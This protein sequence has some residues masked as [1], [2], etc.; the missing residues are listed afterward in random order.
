ME[1]ITQNKVT[2]NDTIVSMLHNINMDKLD[3]FYKAASD[4]TKTL[5][6][7]NNFHNRIERLIAEKPLKFV[8]LNSL[9]NDLKKLI[10]IS[11]NTEENVFLNDLTKELIDELVIEWRNSETFKFHNLGI[12]NK[13]LFHGITGNGK[14]TIARHIAKI[15]NLPFVEINADVMID[16]KL[17]NTQYNI[18]QVLNGIKEP[19]VLFWD[20]IDS[21]GRKRGMVDGSSAGMENERM[22]NSILVNIEKLN[23][24]VIFIGATNRK[25]VLD[26][27]FI[28]RF[29]VVF[30]LTAPSLSEKDL[31]AKQMMDYYK[32]P[33]T[34]MPQTLS[35]Y[36]SYSEIKNM[37][38]DLARKFVLDSLNKSTSETHQFS[39]NTSLGV[40]K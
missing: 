4:Y 36:I 8:Q 20:E 22:V 18:H 24:D 28:R 27:A 7:S 34:F 39:M 21:I 12:R 35:S 15:S 11:T 40:T 3:L 30:E 31:F 2:A 29:D 9:P 19:C 23:N 25:D 1:P 5:A 33:K 6:R 38:M 14:T 17:G 26:T 13:L 10:T 37:F 16:S 32:L